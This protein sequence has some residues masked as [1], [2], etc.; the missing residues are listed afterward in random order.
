MSV[1]KKI[2]D[3]KTDEEVHSDF[4]KFSRG[5]FDNRYLVEAKRQKDR[6]NIKTG[7]EFANFLVRTCLQEVKGEVEVK[8]VIVAAFSVDKEAEFPIERIKQ[9]MGIKQAVVSAK[10]TAD[11]ILK[12]M[13]KYPK[14]FYALSFST[15]L[16]ELKIKPKAPKSAK[17]AASGDKEASA[18]FCII[19][20]SNQSIAQDLL[21][22]L[23]DFSKASIRHTLN[24]KEIVLPKNINDPA[25]LR[26][27][28]KK[29]GTIKRIAR[30]DG[31]EVIKEVGF[32][33]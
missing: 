33:A 30:F 13:D 32:E 17:P 28:A 6:W 24:I 10:T 26:G 20:T 11:K 1:L 8:G 12:L 29:K 21:F 4:V 3:G 2:F 5:V 25:Q 27:L 14:A 23:P 7:A 9:F 15:P 22:G 16:S 19:K 18:D 31:K